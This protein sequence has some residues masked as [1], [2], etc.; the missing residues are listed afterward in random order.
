MRK[1]RAELERRVACDEGEVDLEEERC[2]RSAETSLREGIYAEETSRV[3]W[4]RVD[5]DGGGDVSGGSVKTAE[6]SLRET[7]SEETRRLLRS[8]CSA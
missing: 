3:L 8:H 5:V 7:D 4:S 1:H 2:L 6:A